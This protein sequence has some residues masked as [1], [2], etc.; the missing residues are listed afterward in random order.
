MNAKLTPGIFLIAL[1]VGAL[2]GPAQTLADG[3]SR[4]QLV[5]LAYWLDLAAAGVTSFAR[6]FVALVS[7]VAAALGLPLYQSARGSKTAP[8]TPSVPPQ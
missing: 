4:D 8:E 5:S 2:Y 1:V 7:I 6:E 3:I